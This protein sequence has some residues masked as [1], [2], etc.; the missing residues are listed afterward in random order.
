MLEFNM[1]P[2]KLVALGT[3]VVFWYFIKSARG[4]IEILQIVSINRVTSSDP[5]NRDFW[6]IKKTEIPL[7]PEP[8]MTWTNI[9][10]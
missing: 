6:Y 2:I 5:L 8:K 9:V 1:M 4:N 7:L 10:I 3:Q